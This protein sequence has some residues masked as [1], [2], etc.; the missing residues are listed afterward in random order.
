[1]S[2]EPSPTPAT[3]A[4][5][6]PPAAADETAPATVSRWRQALDIFYATGIF[7]PDEWP[8]R[9]LVLTA[10]MAALLLFVLALARHGIAHVRENEVG[11]LADNLHDELV[12]K[13]R[14][15]YHFFLPYLA[16]FYV[17]DKTIQKRSLTWDQGAG[18]MT[19]RDVKLKTADGN[20]VS[21]DVTVNFKLIPEK[22][23]EILRGSGPDMNFADLWVEPF[24]RH[25]CFASFGRLATEQLYNATNRN[26]MA[27]AAMKDMN[28]KLMPHG[29]EIIAVI[30]GDFRFYHEYEQVIQEKKLADQ[31]VEEQ[32][33]QARA[34]MEDRERQLVEAQKRVETRLAAFEGE[35]TNRLLQALAETD[36]V[37][38][39]AEGQSRVAKIAADSAL[40]TATQQATGRKATLVSEAE[41]MEEMRKAMA[42]DG[43]MGMVAL[44]YARHLNST[45]FSG[46]AVTRQPNVQQFSVQPAEAAA[47]MGGQR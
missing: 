29:I 26:E 45:H 12:L 5:E 4:P 36:K 47:G 44:E 22:A 9:T 8:L 30:P 43:G 17:L 33:A 7:R 27:Q 3:P 20:T 23:V 35:S 18:A 13:D 46:T 40:Y 10:L 15:G 34:A 31:Q 38:R 24:T 11:V 1:M 25:A 42:G 41:G 19:G 6:P 21:L 28:A 39:E 16:N 14:V 37:K 32:Q 2:N